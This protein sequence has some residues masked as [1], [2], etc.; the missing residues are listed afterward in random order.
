[1]KIFEVFTKEFR[2]E[3][4]YREFMKEMLNEFKIN[5]KSESVEYKINRLKQI[6]F[7]S[8]FSIKVGQYT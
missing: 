7:E 1:M 2:E 6:R 8:E 5:N 4:R 3:T